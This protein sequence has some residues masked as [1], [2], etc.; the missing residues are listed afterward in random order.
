MSET[1]YALLQDEAGR[2]ILRFERVLAHPPERVWRALTES[3]ELAAWHPT[4]FEL[5]PAVGGVVDYIPTEGAPS[6]PEG[7]LTA[8]E[9]PR[10]LAHT[11]GKDSLRWELQPH[12]AGSMLTLTHT[13]G[14][15]FK[16]ARDA[17]GWHLCLDALSSSLDGEGVPRGDDGE[18]LPSGWRELNREYEERFGIP[19]EEATPPPTR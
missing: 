6:W 13:F 16:A 4:P 11:W 9:P 3:R 10:L 17:A 5:E 15:R 2:A 14:D 12:P 18:R 1:T 19:S 7:R 8:Y